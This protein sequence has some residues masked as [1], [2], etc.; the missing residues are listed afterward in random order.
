[1]AQANFTPIQLYYSNTP[2]STP[3]A[4]NLAYGELAINIVDGKLYYKDGG[5][6]VRVIATQGTG[7]IG[8]SNTEIQYNNAGALAGSPNL[9]FNGSNLSINGG[10]IVGSTSAGSGV[11]IFRRATIPALN[12]T[13]G[14]VFFS[15]TVDGT[16]LQTGASIVA[17]ASEAWT[18]SGTG[19]RIVFRTS[20][21]GSVGPSD[22]ATLDSEGT[23][24]VVG[25]LI[26]G[27]GSVSSSATITP[28]AATASQYNVTALAVPAT[29]AAPSGTP[30][31]GQKL[32]LRLK[33]NG[34]ARALTWNA[35]Y[36]V[37]GTTLPT[38]TVANKTT[39]V[40]CI[41]NSADTVWDVVA[42]TTQA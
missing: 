17:S 9:T 2:T 8:G 37:I 24:S 27:V 14:N 40:G 11:T 30:V 20:S 15:S 26:A 12:A 13:F 10:A 16:T 21:L 32:I 23:F 34:T 29:I 41:Y 35:I 36:R 28:T 1:M 6:V 18:G 25:A 3:V 7:S 22:K 5:N 38:T 31:N 4:A 42:V 33:D 39:Y 19:S